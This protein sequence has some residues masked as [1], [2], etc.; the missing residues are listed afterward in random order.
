MNAR[1]N[2][3]NNS[4]SENNFEEQFSPIIL[5]FIV[6]LGMFPITAILIS[7]VLGFNN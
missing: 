3:N 4:N 7:R 2:I 5:R 6:V 1:K